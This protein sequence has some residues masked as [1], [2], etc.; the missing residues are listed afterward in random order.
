MISIGGDPQQVYYADQYAPI[1]W[2]EVQMIQFIHGSDSVDRVEPFVRVPFSSREERQRLVMKYGEDKVAEVFP[3]SGPVDM[4]APEATLAR[5]LEWKNPI[6]Q[7][8][9]VTEGE[10]PL[11]AKSVKNPRTG[12]FEPVAAEA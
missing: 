9:E 3:R 10:A 11:V 7:E 8:A 4:E 5:G 6:T 1:S 2:P 12:R